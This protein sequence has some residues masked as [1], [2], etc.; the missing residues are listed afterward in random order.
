MDI[1]REI[2]IREYL[3]PPSRVDSDPCGFFF[4]Y[5]W[6]IVILALFVFKVL[7]ELEHIKSILWIFK[8]EKS[9]LLQ[10]QD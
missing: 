4:S 2:L 8:F 3:L 7:V 6:E 1:E 9:K 5:E 10:C